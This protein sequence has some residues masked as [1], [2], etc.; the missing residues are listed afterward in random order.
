[1]AG[2]IGIAPTFY[3]VGGIFALN[4]TFTRFFTT[5]TLARLNVNAGSSEEEEEQEEEQEEEE[6]GVEETRACIG[7]V[8]NSAAAPAAIAPTAAPTPAPKAAAAMAAA[9]AAAAPVPAPTWG[10]TVKGTVSQCVGTFFG[11]IAMD[12]VTN[13]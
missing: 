9:A 12:S 7:A 11:P 2:S 6:V 13:P 1:L 10:D 5:E 3:I 4:M 8:P